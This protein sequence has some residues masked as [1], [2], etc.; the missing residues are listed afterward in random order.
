MDRQSAHDRVA[1]ARRGLMT[2]EQL[3]RAGQAL[4]GNDGGWRA[5]L[6]DELG[7]GDNIFRRWLA[8]QAPIPDSVI[9][10]VTANLEARVAE[11][12]E[13]LDEL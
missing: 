13:L 3:T 12:A 8:G 6:R 4:Y 10:E 5:R 11:I 9:V 7:A 1:G 2:P